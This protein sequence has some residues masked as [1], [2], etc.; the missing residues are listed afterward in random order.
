MGEAGG[1]KGVWA[2]IE[3]KYVRA[4]IIIFLIYV[5]VLN[6]KYIFFN[7]NLMVILVPILILTAILNINCNVYFNFV[8]NF[9]H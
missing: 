8:T 9:S 6:D 2:Y 3:G 4:C 7:S 1:K 5:V